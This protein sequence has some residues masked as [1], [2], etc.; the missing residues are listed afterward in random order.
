VD[1]CQVWYGPSDDPGAAVQ[2]DGDFAGPGIISTTITGLT[3]GVCYRVWLKAR[4]GGETG[5]FG[6]GTGETPEAPKPVDRDFIYVPGGTVLGSDFFA[7]TVTVPDDSAYNNPG[8]SSL[9]RGV[10]VR[11]RRAALS[12]FAMAKYEITEEL[13]YTVQAWAL[14]R[15][16][17]FQ[18]PKKQAPAEQKKNLPVSG[19]NWRDAV[20]WCNASSEKAGKEPVYSSGGAVIR[21]SRNANAAACDDAAMDKTKSGYRLPTEA[22]REFAARGGDPGMADWM[23]MYAGSDNA[24]EAA[25]HHGNSAY[26]TKAVGGKKANRLGL[27]DLSGNVQEWCWDWMNYAV[28]AGAETPL[29]GAARNTMTGGRN[30]GSQKPFN[31]GGVGSNLTYS[32]VT[33]RWGFTPD[34]RDNY[35][36]FRV[37]YKP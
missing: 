3:N 32:C 25:W 33:Y 11:D 16:Y 18:N 28:D 7:F 14:E 4:A 6:T 10:F 35:V 13:W 22:E 1:S 5:G 27:H 19:V 15:G 8:S 29:D 2:W 37:V 31:G 21:D 24:D 20:V 23:F 12:G 34:Y 36:G 26:Q 17:N 30:A 9:R